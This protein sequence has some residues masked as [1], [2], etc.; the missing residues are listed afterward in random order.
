VIESVALSFFAGFFGT[1][2][3]PEAVGPKVDAALDYV[4]QVKHGNEGRDAKP[5][6]LR[7]VRYHPDTKTW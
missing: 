3:F 1:L 2:M 7:M 6:E 5:G 4:R